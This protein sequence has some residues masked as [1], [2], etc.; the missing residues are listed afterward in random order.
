MRVP[1]PTALACLFVWS[2]IATHCARGSPDLLPP[3]VA[4]QRVLTG[5]GH[6]E[7]PLWDPAGFLLL[8]DT[9]QNVVL[10]YSHSDHADV[11]RADAGC[12]TA[13]C[14]DPQGRLVAN[15]SHGPGGGRRVA[16]LE[17]D[18][19]TWRTLADRFEGKRLNSPNDLTI[20][21]HGR[22]YFTDPRYSKRETMELK[23]EAVYRI[24][25]NGRVSR[26]ID[27]LTRPNG[28]VIAADDRTL[29][30]SDNPGT[31]GEGRCALW[32]FDLDADGNASRGRVLHD[33]HAERGVDG[34][35]LDTD[36]R[37]WAAAGASEK[38]GVYVF[39]LDR[40]RASA[41]IAAFVRLPEPPT[42]CTFGGPERATLFVTTDTSL[43]RIPTL[44]RGLPLPPGK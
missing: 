6:G 17:P 3:H 30:V 4:A 41:R 16:R 24:D 25:P 37:I 23:A 2:G 22:I 31:T 12:T 15:E 38:S 26:I 36:G 42:N 39:E 9:T 34:M 35:T 13:L 27:R 33:F 32:A 44:V 8:C 21:R 7:G 28:I 40:Q 43:Y 19:K 29:Y 5:L 14:F 1:T 20:D 11:F 10:R 18:G